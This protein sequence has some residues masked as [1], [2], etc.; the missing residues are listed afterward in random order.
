MSDRIEPAKNPNGRLMTDPPALLR[1]V[2]RSVFER[3]LGPVPPAGKTNPNWRNWLI[4]R[5][6][7]AVWEPIDGRP[8]RAQPDPNDR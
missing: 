1:H 2:T 7:K 5:R 6:R 3:V 4:G 8:K